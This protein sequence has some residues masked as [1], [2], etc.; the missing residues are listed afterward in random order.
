MSMCFKNVLFRLFSLTL[1]LLCIVL[2]SACSSQ[3]QEVQSSHE[4]IVV[5]A[6]NVS[7]VP[8]PQVADPQAA[9]TEVYAG[10]ESY[11][12]EDMTTV[13][14]SEVSGV[15][16][17]Y[18]YQ[19]YGCFSDPNGGLADMIIAKPYAGYVTE[20]KEALY[21][22]ISRRTSEFESYDVLD[23]FDISKSAIVYEQGDYVIMLML[24][25]NDDAQSVIDKYIPIV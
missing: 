23:S 6:A 16:D 25:D 19:V 1:I 21:K 3:P 13:K 5:M 20:T 7:P 15:I 2:F 4:E 12:A 8:A 14:L 9:V 17:L 10:I 11:S 24:K 18:V 22:Y